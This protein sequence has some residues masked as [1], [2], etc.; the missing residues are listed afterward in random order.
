ML[1]V[2]RAYPNTKYPVKYITDDFS[3]VRE[4]M[5]ALAHWKIQMHFKKA[6]LH[7]AGR[8]IRL[9]AKNRVINRS[10]LS[11]YKSVKGKSLGSP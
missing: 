7:A 9:C 1:F 8:L 10:L 3:V 2:F 11:T 5:R 4:I 6:Q